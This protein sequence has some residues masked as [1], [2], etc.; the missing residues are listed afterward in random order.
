METTK[1][2]RK[3]RAQ[4]RRRKL[5]TQEPLPPK[6]RVYRRAISFWA[7]SALAY[8]VSRIVGADVLLSVVISSAV[9]LMLLLKF[10]M[11]KKSL[12]TLDD[13]LE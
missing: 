8:T 11:L 10:G 6:K 12:Y 4:E 2:R 5:K 1:E 7:F 9:F 13:M 3:R